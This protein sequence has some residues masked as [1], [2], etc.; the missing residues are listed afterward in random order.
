MFPLFAFPLIAGF[1]PPKY[2]AN[3]LPY[4][5]RWGPYTVRV[6][7]KIDPDEINTFAALTFKITDR[8]GRL[9]KALGGRIEEV[10]F[11][12]TGKNLPPAIHV[13]W[14]RELAGHYGYIDYVFTRQNGVRCALLFEGNNYGIK[15]FVDLDGDG[16]KEILADSDILAYDGYSFGSSPAVLVVFG[17]NGRR[18]I[19]QTPRFAWRVRVEANHYQREVE[20]GLRKNRKLSPEN[21]NDDAVHGQIAGYFGNSYEIGR[22][23]NAGRWLKKHL[24]K[25][26]WKWFQEHKN[27]WRQSIL[28]LE[29]VYPTQ[30]TA[31]KPKTRLKTKTTV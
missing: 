18:Y 21:R 19:N 31:P 14:Q 25:E 17:W 29:K 12:K 10:E 9:L 11:V 2:D 26:Q 27:S 3:S 4:Q 7:G 20:I 8:R 15:R 13:V 30:L 23:A 28:A 24:P 1:H 16:Q 22:A 6:A 5:A